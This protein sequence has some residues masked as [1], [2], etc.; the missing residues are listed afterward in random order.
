M[1]AVPHTLPGKGLDRDVEW[2]GE[3]AVGVAKGF[4]HIGLR[5]IDDLAGERYGQAYTN[6]KA[7]GRSVLN[8]NADDPCALL[9]R[10]TPQT[11]WP[12]TCPRLSPN[13]PYELWTTFSWPRWQ[14][15]QVEAPRPTSQRQ[16]RAVSSS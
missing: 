5:A 10:H 7:G 13:L 4:T 9:P 12:A 6:Y 2:A 8:S 1:G 16:P 14:V 15:V 3:Q 11:V